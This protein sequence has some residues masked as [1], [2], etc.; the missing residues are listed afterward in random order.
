MCLLI[1][2]LGRIPHQVHVTEGSSQVKLERVSYVDY[3]DW[4]NSVVFYHQQVSQIV[5]NDLTVYSSKNRTWS[6]VWLKV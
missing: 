5:Q 1:M 2:R 3:I 4:K 6:A